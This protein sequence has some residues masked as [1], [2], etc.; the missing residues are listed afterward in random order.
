[1]GLIQEPLNVDFYIT[2]KQMIEEDQK[3]VSEFIREQKVP[4]RTFSPRCP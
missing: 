4:K 3:R 2:G 1:M